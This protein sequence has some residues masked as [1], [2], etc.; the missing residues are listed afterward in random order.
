[1]ELNEVLLRACEGNALR[2]HPDAGALLD[3]LLLLQ[4]GKSVRRLRRAELH[5]N[6]A[7]RIAAGLAIIAAIAG[8]GAWAERQRANSEQRLRAAAEAERDALARRSVYAARLTQ[9]QQALERDDFGRARRFLAECAPAPGEPDLRGFEWQALQ[10]QAQGDPARVLHAG[11]VAG[12][13]VCVSP[14]GQR[15][16]ALF[17]ESKVRVW[18]LADGRLEQAIDGVTGLAAFSPTAAGC[19][20]RARADGSTA[21]ASRPGARTARASTASTPRSAGSTPSAPGRSSSTSTASRWRCAAGIFRPAGPTRRFRCPIASTTAAITRA[22]WRP[23][24]A[25]SRSRP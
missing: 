18:S 12:L 10:S 23:T 6:R 24:A 15:A 2:R 8:T 21:G 9:A 17:A 16:A 19:W 4:A 13:R 1:M 25:R 3:E 11:G 14:D 22:P 7:L 20:A 5:L